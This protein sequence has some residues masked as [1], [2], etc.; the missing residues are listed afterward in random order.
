MLFLLD[1][2]NE[3]PTID[4]II[5]ENDFAESGTRRTNMERHRR[6]RTSGDDFICS[7]T[8]SEE[9]EGENDRKRRRRGGSD[10][11]TSTGRKNSKNIVSG[12]EFLKFPIRDMGRCQDNAYDTTIFQ[13][14]TSRMPIEE[15]VG[16]TEKS[17]PIP[18]QFQK[19]HE[20]FVKES[21]I[22][23]NFFHGLRESLPRR[24]ILH[25]IYSSRPDSGRDGFLDHC[26]GTKYTGTIFII[27][28]HNDHFHVIHDCSYSGSTCRCQRI[29]DIQSEYI[30]Y[31]RRVIPTAQF[32]TAHWHNLTVY[33]EKDPRRINYIYIAGRTWK[34]SGKNRNLSIFGSV[35]TREEKLV[36]NSRTEDNI[37]TFWECETRE[38][39]Q[40]NNEGSGDTFQ[41]LERSQKR[42]KGDRLYEFLSEFSIAPIKTI[43]N[44]KFWTLGKYRYDDTDS[45]LMNSVLRRIAIEISEWNINDFMNKYN[46]T[47]NN[48]LIFNAPNANPGDYYYDINTSVE[49]LN[50]LLLFQYDNNMELVKIFLEDVYNVCE[51]KEPKRNSIFIY[52]SPNAG[53]NYF[54]DCVVH[55]HLNFGQL[56]NFNKYCNFPLQECV[57]K[58][59]IMWNEPSVSPDHFETIKTILGGDNANA[60]IKHQGDSIVARTPIIILGNTEPFPK[61]SAFQTR[62]I[63][64]TWKPCDALAECSK[65]P[66]PLAYYYLLKKYNI[67]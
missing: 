44:T 20:I 15:E 60:K 19:Q 47:D 32:S 7:G 34:E 38:D 1:E 29:A 55:F 62:I 25:D 64:Y 21:T 39:D 66:T 54:F 45:K 42:S 52:S 65:K 58:R 53:K 40:R 2:E 27:A 24:R 61:D 43:F 51:K 26:M 28:E 56:G 30:R 37:S 8:S 46:N 33:L 57:N 63:K 4:Q 5:E 48:K 59:I 14:S 17:I 10:C 6:R 13:P 31:K 41:Q 36:E 22:Y 35:K 12:W 18:I 11:G 49:V 3:L 50:E 23:K 16:T 67:V 9:E